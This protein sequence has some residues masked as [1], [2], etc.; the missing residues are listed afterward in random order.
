MLKT[1]SRRS[2]ESLRQ[3][4]YAP[5]PRVARDEPPW[6]GHENASNPYGVA[7]RPARVSSIPDILL[8][9][10]L[11]VLPKE[12]PQFILKRHLAVVFF[13]IRDVL[14][15]FVEVGLAHGEIRV[16]A[17]PGEIGQDA[18][19]LLQSTSRDAFQFLDPFGLADLSSEA[20]EQ[21]HVI[22]GAANLDGRALQSFG[23]A[24]EIPVE[25]RL[26]GLI[27]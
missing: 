19:L 8:V 26:E 27:L 11:L 15:H 7:A 2:N 13:L 24:T 21:V 23:N 16:S 12:F 9:P 18:A 17:L 1:E 14:R 25:I 4:R 3:R 5:E 22:R 10:F 6:V 20:A